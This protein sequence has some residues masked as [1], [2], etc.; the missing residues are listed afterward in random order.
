MSL[1]FSSLMQH[2]K[3]PFSP[4]LFA[5]PRVQRKLILMAFWIATRYGGGTHIWDCQYSSIYWVS[6]CLFFCQFI[7][8]LGI[9]SVKASLLIFYFRLSPKLWYRYTVIA[10]AIFV[11]LMS[12]ALLIAMIFQCKPI[13][14]W[15]DF[16]G[17]KCF[18]MLAYWLSFGALSMISDVM[19]WYVIEVSKSEENIHVLFVMICN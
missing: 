6:K 5:L 2:C 14:F 8:I 1:V 18:D 3:K 12:F 4:F 19:I 15:N 7:Y 13:A 17:K 10:V 9:M 16:F 11:G